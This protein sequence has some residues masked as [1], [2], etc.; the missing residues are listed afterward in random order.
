MHPKVSVVLATLGRES[1]LEVL[2]SIFSQTVPVHE[3]IVCLDDP[4]KESYLRS[5]IT[6]KFGFERI[7]LLVN[8]ENLG[9]SAS[10]NRAIS[11]TTG[12]LIA[13]ASDDDPWFQRKIEV[14]IE[15]MQRNNMQVVSITSCFF[16]SEVDSVKVRPK[17][18]LVLNESPLEWVYGY[19]PGPAT[20]TRYLPMSSAMFPAKLKSLTFDESMSSR[21]DL[22]WLQAA[23]SLGYPV[24][25]NEYPGIR[26]WSSHERSNNRDDFTE[27]QFLD[28]LEAL[29]SGMGKLFLFHHLTR[30]AIA[31]GSFR[32]Y[33][34]LILQVKR[35]YKLRF[36]DFPTI[37]WQ[38]IACL[39]FSI[40]GKFIAKSVK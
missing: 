27:G 19:K 30:S 24:F 25:Q 22:L 3:V 4:S 15:D 38:L 36:S 9:V 6:S 26:V 8:Q 34:S 7:K 13:V 17:D 2:T 23:H 20:A 12:D 11:Q 33:L 18:L 40:K 5:I 14:Q 31:T 35:R 16:S 10:Y 1:I 32:S 39:L 37:A 29:K 28:A 21:E